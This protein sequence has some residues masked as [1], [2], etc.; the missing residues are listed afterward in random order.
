[1][2]RQRF[3]FPHRSQP[4]DQ[5]TPQF[6]SVSETASLLGM[7]EMTLYRAIAAGEF[8]AVRIRGR[9]IIPGRAID[10]MIETAL[11]DGALVDAERWVPNETRVAGTEYTSDRGS[12]PVIPMIGFAA[13][14]L[15][16]SL[17]FRSLSGLLVFG[18]LVVVA[19]VGG[20]VWTL[21]QE[22]QANRQFRVAFLATQPPAPVRRFEG[23]APAVSAMAADGSG[24]VE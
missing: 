22:R 23:R 2:S 5:S 19:L 12:A 17:A 18:L 16:A 7:S 13:F 6:L 4:V 10:Q 8:P 14:L 11:T 9:L 1:M 20:V 15:F 21:G 3:A 24:D